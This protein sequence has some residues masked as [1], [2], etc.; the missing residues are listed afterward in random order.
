ME[1]QESGKGSLTV[2]PPE[3]AQAGLSTARWPKLAYELAVGVDDAATL[4][5]RHG[6][7][8]DEFRVVLNHPLFQ[9][10]LQEA[11]ADVR[12]NGSGFREKA[13]VIAEDLLPDLY[14]I[15]K[16]PNVHPSIRL[17]TAKFVTEA[18]GLKTGGRGDGTQ[19]GGG[20]ARFTLRVLLG[21]REERLVGAVIDVDAST[22]DLPKV[23][24]Q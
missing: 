10:I 21:E 24:A 20:G 3:P 17:D 7:T 9:R 12:T 23:A 13:K 15:A 16:N 14:S 5:A 4:A 18:A 6:L 22:D 19:A 11:V 2:A 1:T 8:F